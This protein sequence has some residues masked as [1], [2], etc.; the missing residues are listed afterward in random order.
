MLAFSIGL[1]PTFYYCWIYSGAG[2]ANFFYSIT[3]LYAITQ[4]ILVSDVSIA[5]L[6]YDH[7]INNPNHK[8]LKLILS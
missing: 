7:L 4:I 6:K 8:D 5:K 1:L 3:L 2:N